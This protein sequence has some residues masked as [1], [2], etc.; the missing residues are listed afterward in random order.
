[1]SHL[2]CQM[3]E[4]VILLAIASHKKGPATAD[5]KC[6]RQCLADCNSDK[7]TFHTVRDDFVIQS[8]VICM[9]ILRCDE[10]ASG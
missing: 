5:K 7:Q 2:S 1:M 3:A 9:G 4:V 6:L 8:H 10:V